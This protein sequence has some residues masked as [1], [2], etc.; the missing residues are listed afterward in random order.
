M[1]YW[2]RRSS[3]TATSK[4]NM[5]PFSFAST[6]L[7][8]CRQQPRL[9]QSYLEPLEERHLLACSQSIP[10][11]NLT[12]TEPASAEGMMEGGNE[13]DLKPQHIFSINLVT[14]SGGGTLPTK[15]VDFFVQLGGQA[16]P[17]EDYVP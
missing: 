14:G 9:H 15:D 7:R 16:T 17:D 10:C 2:L 12:W 11:F 5:L 4:W 13:H 6:P 1:R 8:K 3:S